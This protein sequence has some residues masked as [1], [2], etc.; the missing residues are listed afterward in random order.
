MPEIQAPGERSAENLAV[1]EDRPINWKGRAARGRSAPELRCETLNESL[2]NLTSSNRTRYPR[3]RVN[4]QQFYAIG[5][6]PARRNIHMIERMSPPMSNSP[7]PD[8]GVEITGIGGRV[9]VA[10][11]VID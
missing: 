9:L 11:A 5:L 7:A 3:L 8:D 10:V 1:A 4:G 2:S 6:A